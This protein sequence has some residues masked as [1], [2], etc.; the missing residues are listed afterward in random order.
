MSRTAP[1]SPWPSTVLP[2]DTALT[3][4]LRERLTTLTAERQA[5]LDQAQRQLAAYDAVIGE[6]TA[7]LATPADTTVPDT[8]DDR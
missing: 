6:L 8:S 2:P 4:R 5:L 7:L 1:L 3:D